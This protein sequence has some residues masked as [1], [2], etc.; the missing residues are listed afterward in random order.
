MRTILVGGLI[1]L[2]LPAWAAAQY[3]ILTP[4]GRRVWLEPIFV[5]DLPFRGAS[6]IRY[7]QYTDSEGR[8]LIHGTYTRVT[9]TGQIRQL[10]T[11][12]HG[13][14]HGPFETRYRN[15][16]LELQGTYQ[17]NRLHGPVVWYFHSGAI[18]RVET[19]RDGELD[20]PF[21]VYHEQGGRLVEGRYRHGSHFLCYGP[22]AIRS[23]S[24]CHCHAG[25]RRPP[26]ERGA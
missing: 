6:V 26:R 8:E 22:R 23:A 1:F 2:L 10:V 21:V 15:G 16:K 14:R 3:P 17:A 5:R 19:Y 18:Q 7:S 11:Y 13:L 12:V 4:D 9:H 20:G 25:R 24:R